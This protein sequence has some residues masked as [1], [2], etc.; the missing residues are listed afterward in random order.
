MKR[1]EF[2]TLLGGAATWP[3]VA[4]A[5]QAAMPGAG[6]K[7]NRKLSARLLTL[8]R[9]PGSSV[10]VRRNSQG[11]GLLPRTK[12]CEAKAIR[13]T[14]IPPRRTAHQL[15]ALWALSNRGNRPKTSKCFS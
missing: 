9:T 8:S 5:Q 12:N 10:F 13:N 14:P 7:P 15:S 6:C 2:M 4:R 3:L 1:R 11:T